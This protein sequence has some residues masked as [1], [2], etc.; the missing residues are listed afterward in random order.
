MELSTQTHL[1]VIRKALMTREAELL[2]DVRAAEQSR[3]TEFEIAA[4]EP[5]DHKDQSAGM[6]EADVEQAQEQRD[7]RELDRVRAALTRLDTGRFGDCIDCGEPIPWKRLRVQ[8]DAER[9]A[10]CQTRAEQHR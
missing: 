5:G 3:R 9:C 2:A 7:V 6:Q 4:A 10:P 8:L 1:T